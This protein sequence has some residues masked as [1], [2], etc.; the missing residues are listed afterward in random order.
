MFKV[1]PKGVAYGTL[2][3]FA[4]VALS[5]VASNIL[6]VS[7]LSGPVSWIYLGTWILPGYLAAK[8]AGKSGPVNGALVGLVVGLLVGS[9]SQL[10]F[11]RPPP[12]VETVSGV[13]V[14][15]RMGLSAIVLCGLGGLIW[16]LRNGSRKNGL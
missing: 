11:N 13:E 5:S 3:F 4:L 10:F 6:N 16:Q 2:L 1:S 9:V 15:L 7:L 8:V 14:G 12:I